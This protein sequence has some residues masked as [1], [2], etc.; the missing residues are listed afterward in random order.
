MEPLSD[1]ELNTAA[2]EFA[3]WMMARVKAG[4]VDVEVLKRRFSFELQLADLADKTVR[5]HRIQHPGDAPPPDGVEVMRVL[6]RQVDGRDRLLPAIGLAF[7]TRHGNV[8]T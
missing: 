2:V 8:L 3:D 6:L 4:E 5:D 7:F 1:A